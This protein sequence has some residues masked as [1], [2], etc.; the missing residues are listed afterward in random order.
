M[1]DSANDDG[2]IAA[3]L[4]R[5]QTVRLPRALD[6]KARVDSGEKLHESDIAYLHRVFEDAQHIQRL[7]DRH[8]EYEELVDRATHLYNEITRKALENEQG[9]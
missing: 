8:P 7:L 1:N 5:F 2:V 9:Q 4:Q 3:L 6:L